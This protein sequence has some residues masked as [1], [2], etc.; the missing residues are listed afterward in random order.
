MKI[1]KI[2]GLVLGTL[3][4][5]LVIAAIVAGSLFDPNDYKGVAADAFTK[6]TGRSLNV[7]RELKLSYFP[8]LAVETGG[9]TI[10]NAAGFGSEPFATVE[11]VAARVKL[12]PLLHSQIEIGTVELE[13]LHVNLARDKQLRGNWQDLVDALNRPAP[14]AAPAAPAAPGTPPQSFALEGVRVSGG[15]I[16]WRE[17]TSELRYV[18]SGLNVTTGSI[19]RGEPVA[20]DLALD[21]RDEVSALTAKLAVKAV[22]QVAENGSVTATGVSADVTVTTKGAPPRKLSAKAASIAFDSGAQTLAAEGLTT[23]TAGVRAAWQLKGSALVDNPTV[24]GSVQV[25]DAPLAELFDALG[26]APPQGLS[27]G[28]LG[29]LSLTS[30]LHFRSQPQEVR[31]TGLDAKALGMQIKGEGT[32]TGADEL[33]GRVE[34]PEFAPNK[35]VQ[36][37]LKT[38]APATV[39]VAAIDKLALST[40]FDTNLTTGRAAL[41]DL[42]ATALGA[43]LSGDVQVT[44]SGKSSSYR[45]SVQ[46]SRFAPDAFAKAFAGM[47]PAGVKAQQ[48]GM[49]QLKAQFALDSGADTLSVPSFDAEIFGLNA[50]GEVNGRNVT[51]TASWT[52]RGHV[53]QFSP[54]SLIQRFGL[55]PQPTSDPKALTRATVDM[56]FDVDANSAKLSNVALAL[57]DTK[58]TG[59]FTLDGFK[60][61]KYRFALVVDRVD[62]DRYLP[63]KASEAKKGEATAGDLKLPENNT[64]NLDGTMQIGDLHLAGM[65]F[66]SVGS[67]ILLGG[68]DAKLENA[69]AKLYG[70]DFN[71]NFFVHAAG[72]EPGLNLDGKATGLQL[73]PIIEALTGQPANFS[74]TGSFVLNLAGHGRTITENV[75]TAGGTASFEMLNG[76]IKGFNV[77]ATICKL[78]NVTQNAPAPPDQPKQTAYE[79]MKGGATVKDGTASSNDMLARTA[80]MDI[81]AHGALGLVDQKLD[82]G[83]DAKLTNKIA[84]PN[85]NTLDRHVGLSIPFTL[86]GTISEPTILPDFSKLVQRAIREEAKDKAKDKLLDRLLKH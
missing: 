75:K 15:T 58:I 14:E 51:K 72:K 23:E 63:P 41:R 74:G 27:K 49:V 18:V 50:S 69:R 4:V 86:K 52:G 6:S 37:L 32:L 66:Q 67:R 73:Q 62:A 77:G 65:Q 57:D 2:V 68:G 29:N 20:M 34:I 54:Q 22:A 84:I 44:P 31:L 80:Y 60:D 9:V 79:F 48:L 24:D 5:L 42:K 78:Y 55:P 85:C 70:G 11:R 10:G 38:Y 40:R 47:L 64:M 46:T 26:V 33:A 28:D 7:E 76:A 39:D 3:V 71:G 21:V 17:N 19:G 35:A 36:G 53:A 56:R 61:P 83:V 25:S 43:T 30:Q 8:W 45:G 59:D 82:Y 13:G 16:N 12:L 81:N 1:F